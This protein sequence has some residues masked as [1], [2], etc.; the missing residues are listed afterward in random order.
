[1]VIGDIRDGRV[2]S[3]PHHL[4]G[5]AWCSAYGTG[6]GGVAGYEGTKNFVYRKWASHCCL[7]IQNFIFPESFVGW[8]G[9][10]VWGGGSARSAPFPPL[11]STSLITSLQMR[12][13]LP[14]ICLC[15]VDTRP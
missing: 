1:M 4:Q 9:G 15:F 2:L 8:V 6:G 5:S 3:A 11:I 10:L 13:A 14:S 7:S 12:Q